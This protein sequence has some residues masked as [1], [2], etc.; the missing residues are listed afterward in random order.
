[1]INSLRNVLIFVTATFFVLSLV[2]CYESS[3]S[4]AEPGVKNDEAHGKTP[5]RQAADTEYNNSNIEGD[6]IFDSIL[7]CHKITDDSQVSISDSTALDYF[8]LE[9]DNSK[10]PT[11]VSID[12]NKIDLTILYLNKAIRQRRS[13]LASAATNDQF[14][15]EN[16]KLSTTLIGAIATVLVSIKAGFRVM[17]NVLNED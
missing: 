17:M 5:A 13:D 6:S 15:M 11:D 7:R 1:M 9:I 16:W 10:R 8:P 4:T 14:S 2:G 3:K 12:F